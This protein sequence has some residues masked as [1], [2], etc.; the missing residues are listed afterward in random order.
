MLP[1]K[2]KNGESPAPRKEKMPTMTN[3]CG[4]IKLLITMDFHYQ[5]HL[6]ERYSIQAQHQKEYNQQLL[7]SS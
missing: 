3:H 2:K 4:Q 6:L 5:K 1:Q 7:H